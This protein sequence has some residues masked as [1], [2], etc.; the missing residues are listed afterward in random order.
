[1]SRQCLATAS[2]RSRLAIGLAVNVTG[3]VLLAQAAAHALA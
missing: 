3:L 1:M 2:T